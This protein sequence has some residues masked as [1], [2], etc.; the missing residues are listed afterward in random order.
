M[1][2]DSFAQSKLQSQL[3]AGMNLR[4]ILLWAMERKSTS[5]GD[6]EEAKKLR[7]VDFDVRERLDQ[8]SLRSARIFGEAN[9]QYQRQKPE[10]IN[11][12]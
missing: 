12:K 5:C 6:Q 10:E 4:W 1:L 7:R 2:R 11:T 9:G 8:K 3:D